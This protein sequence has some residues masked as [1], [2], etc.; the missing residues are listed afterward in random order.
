MAG[1]VV[2]WY[3]FFLYATAATLV[4]SKIFFPP[5]ATYSTP[6]SPRSS[7]TRSASSPARSAA[8]C[9]ATSATS[10]AARS[11]AV[12][13]HAG[14]RRDVPDGL[15]ADVR[16]DRLLGAGAAGGPALRPGLRRRRRVGRGRAAGRRAQ[17]RQHRADSGPVG[18]RPAVPVGNMLATVVLLGSAGRYRTTQFLSWGWRVAFWL[19]AVIV[20]VGYYIRTKVTDAPIFLEAQERSRQTRTSATACSRWSSATRA[21]S[22]PRWACGSPR[23]SC[24]TSWSRSRSRT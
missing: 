5:P 17:P 4:F 18:R 13:D 24:T 23:T 15:P 22:S 14:G 2:E 8:S 7:P 1:T 6:S 20:S 16:A 9:S 10:T 12:R 3:E 19:S 21:A 11:S